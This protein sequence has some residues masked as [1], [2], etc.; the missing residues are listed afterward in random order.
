[1]NFSAPVVEGLA[2]VWLAMHGA[3]A[4]T[5]LTRMIA[6][7]KA[8]GY[9]SSARSYRRILNAVG[10]LRLKERKLKSLRRAARST[11]SR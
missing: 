7:M 10:T 11:S 8:S 6:S 4:E 2:E 5:H 1:M 9:N 3:A